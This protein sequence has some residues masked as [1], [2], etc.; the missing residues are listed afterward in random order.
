MK[1]KV[2]YGGET[3]YLTGIGGYAFDG[4]QIESVTIPEGVT[5]LGEACFEDQRELTKVVL[6]SSVTEIG[7]AAFEGCES[8][9]K[10]DLGGTETIGDYAFEGCMCLK[11]LILPE[12]IRSVG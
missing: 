1:Y 10:I 2:E 6:P 4:S 9:S 11:E 7:T 3:Y 5:T 8:L 12:S